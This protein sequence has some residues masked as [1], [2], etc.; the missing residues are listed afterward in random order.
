MAFSK[1]RHS[2]N[3]GCGSGAT[4]DERDPPARRL[5]QA[6]LSPLPAPTRDGAPRPRIR[7]RRYIIPNEVVSHFLQ[8]VDTFGTFRGV[9]G[10]GFQWQKME[11]SFL[12]EH[13]GMTNQQSGVMVARVDPLSP[14]AGVLREKDI[15]MEIDGVPIAD[16]GTIEFRGEERLDFTHVL[17]RR[18]C[19]DSAT[20]RVLR[21]G[22]EME[23]RFLLARPVPL[24]PIMHSVDCYPSFL[25]VGGFVFLPLS[26]PFLEHGYGTSWRKLCPPKLMALIGEYR[27]FP[28]EQVVLLFQ[29]LSAELNYGCAPPAAP[30]SPS[31]SLSLS[32]SPVYPAAPHSARPPVTRRPCTLGPQTRGS[33]CG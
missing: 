15:L 32:R 4:R 11:N 26:L 3:I 1:L 27:S 25:I 18:H 8:E 21:N 14:A 10:R 16:D 17:R 31:L 2:D 28:D 20:A 12:R 22:Q 13:Y 29:I 9:I 23:V 6:F 30:R 19:G 24:V 33:R 7:Y 5:L